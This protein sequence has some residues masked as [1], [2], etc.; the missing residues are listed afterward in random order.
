MFSFLIFFFFFFFFFSVIKNNTGKVSGYDFVKCGE[1]EK[2]FG[3]TGII[4]FPI[5]FFKFLSR[6]EKTHYY[7]LP[8]GGYFHTGGCPD[9]VDFRVPFSDQ[10]FP[11]VPILKKSC[12]RKNQIFSYKNAYFLVI[13]CDKFCLFVDV[14]FFLK[15]IFTSQTYG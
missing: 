12:C 10:I 2:N 4:Y 15:I 6:K 5:N 3:Y 13:F 1:K 9:A 7:T 8:R 11:C 14:K